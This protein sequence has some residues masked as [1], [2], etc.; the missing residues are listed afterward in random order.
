MNAR[1]CPTLMTPSRNLVF[2]MLALSALYVRINSGIL[3]AVL[4]HSLFCVS[5]C[6]WS[7]T[8]SYVR[9]IPSYH[10]AK[11][12][13][14]VMCI[15]MVWVGLSYGL[16]MRF[17]ACVFMFH[18][19]KWANCQSIYRV[20]KELAG[21]TTQRWPVKSRTTGEIEGY[22][23][24]DGFCYPRSGFFL[25]GL[26]R[27]TGSNGQKLI[28]Q[29]FK[30]AMATGP[31]KAWH[32][33]G[34]R[35]VEGQYQLGRRTGHWKIWD[36]NGAMIAEGDFEDDIPSLNWVFHTGDPAANTSVSYIDALLPPRLRESSQAPKR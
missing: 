23:E 34:E 3:L 17:A 2:G 18:D 24:A 14:C 32:P 22:I 8:L 12:I 25:D 11:R 30:L 27:F 9:V 19:A 20:M 35:F 4:I 10:K 31:C 5:F 16:A 33:N 28:D 7:Y 6:A 13:V 36:T 26:W 15:L 29:Q 21:P 1:L